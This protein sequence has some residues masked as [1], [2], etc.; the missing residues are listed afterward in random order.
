MVILREFTFKTVEYVVNLRKARGFQGVAGVDGSIAAA[1]NQ[2][3]RPADMSGFFDMRYEMRIN[4]PIRSVLP[5][6]VD[7]ADRM[8]DKKIFDFAAAVDKN[9]VGVLF[10]KL[11]G[12]LGFQMLHRCW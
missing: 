2:H 10:Q 8:T 1:A 6:D 5:R 7:G 4:F 3:H 12:G 9:D 11:V